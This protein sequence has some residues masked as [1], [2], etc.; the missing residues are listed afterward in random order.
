MGGASRRK[1]S[2]GEAR[3]GTPCSTGAD[4]YTFRALGRYWVTSVAWA[5]T[6]CGMVRPTAWAVLRLITKS[7]LVGCSS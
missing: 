2:Y 6:D 3:A 5:S 4:N 1:T 7:S